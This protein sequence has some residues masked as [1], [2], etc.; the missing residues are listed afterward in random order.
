MRIEWDED[1]RQ[2]TLRE[3]G[4]DFADVALVDWDEA[5]TLEDTRQVYAEQ[6]FITYAPIRD[7]LCVIAWCF[8]GSSM[9][10]FSLRKANNRER[11][12]HEQS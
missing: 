12:K 5:L 8:R 3:R 4:L 6:R 9:R 2:Q 10:V 11:R 7:R 1:K